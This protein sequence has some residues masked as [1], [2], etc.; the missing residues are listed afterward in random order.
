[1]V[2]TL[3]GRTTLIARTKSGKGKARAKNTL[4]KKKN[5]KQDLLKFKKKRPFVPI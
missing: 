5:Q 2:I 3:I 1:M 4:F